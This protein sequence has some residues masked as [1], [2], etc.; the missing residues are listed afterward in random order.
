MSSGQI[1]L[2]VQPEMGSLGVPG[3]KSIRPGPPELDGLTQ[4]QT[5]ELPSRGAPRSLVW[6]VSGIRL[7]SYLYSMLQP[8]SS[9]ESRR[10]P[11]RSQAMAG[12]EV[13]KR[14]ENEHAS[15]NSSYGVRLDSML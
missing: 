2:P 11:L 9:T 6:P 3:Q 15:R 1:A 4:G 14:L 5:L 13:T 12:G 10:T 7:D 8:S